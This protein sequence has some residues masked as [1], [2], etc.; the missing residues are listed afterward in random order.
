[1]FQANTDR[2]QQQR[3]LTDDL[4]QERELRRKKDAFLDAASHHIN[5]PLAAVVGFSELLRDRTR[6]F[7]AGVR[8]EIIE[9]LAIQALETSHV[10]DDL[11]IAARFD[12][13]ERE[14]DSAAVDLRAVVETATHDWASN[15][16]SRL[17]VSGNAVARA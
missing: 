14:L 7:S 10:V 2:R 16:R 9:L 6:D 17:V 11:L 3:D 4:E 5:N 12:L 8:N 15:Q 1:M 13:D